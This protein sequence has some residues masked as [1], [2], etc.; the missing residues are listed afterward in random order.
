MSKQSL[1]DLLIEVRHGR[2]SNTKAKAAIVEA[3][4]GLIGED[5][6]S[7]YLD[8]YAPEKVVIEARND[9]RAEIRQAIKEWQ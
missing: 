3:V 8:Q 5:E 7:S 4:E 2:M 1:D 6:D 9:V